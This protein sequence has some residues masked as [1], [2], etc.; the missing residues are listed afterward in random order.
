MQCFGFPSK[1]ESAGSVASITMT[2][3]HHHY[4]I[5]I[6]SDSWPWECASVACISLALHFLTMKLML[7]TCNDYDKK[8]GGSAQS[9]H[10]NDCCSRQLEVLSQ[11]REGKS[12]IILSPNKSVHTAYKH[13]HG[14]TLAQRQNNK[15]QQVWS[16]LF[17]P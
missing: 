7:L 15:C 13:W 6:I 17:K 3:L 1:C 14:V 9:E 2:S 12:I 8:I 5:I 10:T 4:D 16:N 11:T